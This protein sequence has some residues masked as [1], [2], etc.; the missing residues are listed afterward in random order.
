MTRAIASFAAVL[1]CVARSAAALPVT[2]VVNSTADTVTPLR[3][4]GAVR[5]G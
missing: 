1:V 3:D 4:D 5:V 2:V